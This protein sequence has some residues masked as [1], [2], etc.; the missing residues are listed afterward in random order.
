MNKNSIEILSYQ[1][2]QQQKKQSNTNSKASTMLTHM[3]K[4]EHRRIKKRCLYVCNDLIE[5]NRQ[6]NKLNRNTTFNLKSW[7]S[8]WIQHKCNTQQRNQSQR[9]TIRDKQCKECA[10]MELHVHN[11]FNRSTDG[12]N[13]IQCWWGNDH[14]IIV[15]WVDS[16]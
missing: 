10:F 7:S 13:C 4:I 15:E 11:D 12:F 16:F 1:Q 3:T 5:C 6:C 2:Q 9:I 8:D 14:K